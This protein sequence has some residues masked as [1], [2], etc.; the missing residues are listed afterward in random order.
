MTS[1][2]YFLQSSPAFFVSFCSLIGLMVGS[3]L[4]VVIY[5]LPKMMEQE[6][7]EQCAEL[8]GET[9]E[10][11]PQFNIVAPRSAC[12][13]CGHKITA[14]ENIPLI[15]YAAL[16]GRCSQCR[17]SISVRYP[18]VEALTA[19]ISGFIAWHFGFGFTAFAAMA[20]A[21][22]MIALAFIDI[23]TQLLPNDITMPLL[24]GGLL[25]N[26]GGGFVDIRS[27]VI[28]AVAGYLALWSVYWGFK[29]ITG[30]EGMGY[31]DFKLLAVIGAWFGW[32]VLPLVILFSSIVGSVIG[33]SLIVIAKRGRHIPI[34]FGPYLA[35]G[36]IVALLWGNEINRAYF[37]LF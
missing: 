19:I 6:W 2:I 16:R 33:I 5:R 4:N 35:G 17:T 11:T 15:S 8:R 13:K 1:F 12:P 20:F 36:G 27:A 3:F 7:R 32:Q 21:W 14:L 31:G 24:W 10:A 34:P 23:D 9:L 25:I 26:L 37:E 30:K 29:A 18:A 22:A 28:G